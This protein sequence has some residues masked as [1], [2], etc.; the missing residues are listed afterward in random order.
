MIVT[1]LKVPRNG[2]FQASSRIVSHLRKS[3]S[4]CNLGERL[5][6]GLRSLAQGVVGE[7][8]RGHR[9]DHRHGARE[10]AGIMTSASGEFGGLAGGGDGL[11][12]FGKWSRSA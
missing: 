10:H 8:Q 2:F 9:L 4:E 11:L 12:L 1:H 7:H 6:A 3:K 5:F